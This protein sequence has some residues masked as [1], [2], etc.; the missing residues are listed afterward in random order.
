MIEDPIPYPFFKHVLFPSGD[1]FIMFSDGVDQVAL[2][3]AAFEIER[4]AASLPVYPALT[5]SSTGREYYPNHKHVEFFTGRGG[6]KDRIVNSARS[7]GSLNEPSL[8]AYIAAI[9]SFTTL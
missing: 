1:E 6:V 3:F 9:A 2:T 7:G 4:A 8:D 5:L